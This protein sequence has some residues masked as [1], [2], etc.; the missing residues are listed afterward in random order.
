MVLE[1]SLRLVPCKSGFRFIG[2]V[3]WDQGD[4]VTVSTNAYVLV[5]MYADF[6]ASDLTSL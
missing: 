5:C 3:K 4:A 1:F 2:I 6:R